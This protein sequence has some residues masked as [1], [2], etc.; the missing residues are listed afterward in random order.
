[1]ADALVAGEPTRLLFEALEQFDRKSRRDGMTHFTAVL[2]PR[3][4]VPFMRALQR[5]ELELLRDDDAP[6]GTPEQRAADALVVL[7]LRVADASASR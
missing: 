7:V 3:L 5:V 1:M 4:G 2:E 6:A